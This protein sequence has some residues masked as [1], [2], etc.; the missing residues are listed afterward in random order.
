MVFLATVLAGFWGILWA[1]FLQCNE[2][3]RYLALRR[4]WVAVV[5]GVGVDL[6]LLLFVIPLYSW[7]LVGAIIAASSVGV[8]ARSLYNEH[9]DERAV[10]EIEHE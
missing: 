4:T 8:I 2:Y 5:V 1:L 10:R 7:L 3:G 6:L 9:R